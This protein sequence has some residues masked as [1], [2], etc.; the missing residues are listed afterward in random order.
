MDKLLKNAIENGQTIKSQEEKKV[1]QEREDARNAHLKL[2]ESELPK[3]RK[4]IKEILF[5][6][7]A[8]EEAKSYIYRSI[9]L[10]DYTYTDGVLTEAIY[11]AAKEIEGLKPRYD[12]PAIYEHAEFQGVGDPVY[13]IEWESSDSS[14]NKNK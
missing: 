14:N 1:A 7:I 13:R 10:G 8:E 9:Y 12:R 3:A 5:A 2:V 11:E 6:K 4:W